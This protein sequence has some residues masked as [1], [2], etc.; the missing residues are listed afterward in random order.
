MHDESVGDIQ[1]DLFGV[2]FESSLRLEA[3]ARPVSNSDGKGR[4]ASDDLQHSESSVEIGTA[5]AIAITS[6]GVSRGLERANYSLSNEHSRVSGCGHGP[7]QPHSC[8]CPATGNTKF[9]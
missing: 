1:V 5:E 7:E 6:P 9:M 3:C 2:E 4:A 8:W